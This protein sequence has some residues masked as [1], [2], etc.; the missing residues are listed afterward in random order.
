ML[1]FWYPHG[2]CFQN[3]PKQYLSLENS[4]QMLIHMLVI[5]NLRIHVECPHLTCTSSP[6]ITAQ[7][8]EIRISGTIFLVW[9]NR[10]Y[11]AAVFTAGLVPR[12]YTSH[13]QLIGS[14][15]YNLMK[16]F[17]YGSPDC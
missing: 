12:G 6:V 14:L 13:V 4:V 2:N 3:R 8:G 9:Y 7:I 16:Q 10:N 17:K 1:S 11:E 15:Q 5:D